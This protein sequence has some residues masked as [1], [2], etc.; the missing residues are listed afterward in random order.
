M[1]QHYGGSQHMSSTNFKRPLYILVDAHSFYA[2]CERVFRPDL[3]TKPVAVMS[4]NDGCI[5]AGTREVKELGIVLG[6]PVFK[7]RHLVKAHQI[8]LFSA[9]FTLYGDLSNRMMSLMHTFSSDV[10][11]YSVDECFIKINNY[12][13]PYELGEE[14]RKTIYNHIGLPVGV[15]LGPT[16]TLAKLANR[17]AKKNG[18]VFYLTEQDDHILSACPMDMVWGI[19]RNHYRHLARYGI[20]NA[21]H[22]KLAHESFVKKRFHVPGHRTQLELKGVPCIEMDLSVTAKKNILSSRSFGK[23]LTNKEDIKGAIGE[24]IATAATK[25]K[26][27]KAHTQLLTIFISTHRMKEDYYSRSHTISLPEPS[28]SVPYLTHHGLK[29]LDPIF[30]E[31]RSYVKS[32]VCFSQL[33]PARVSQGTLF[34]LSEKLNNTRLSSAWDKIVTKHGKTA[35]SIAQTAIKH[36]PWRMNQHHLSPKY[37]TQ[38][39]EIPTAY[40]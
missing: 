35:I 4:N 14:I 32:G 6:K 33:T 20:R 30:L 24:N 25:L 17:L 21:L 16:K 7:I 22:F 29:A 23:A 38:W 12:R 27:E 13:D 5:I 2:S 15:G 19:G 28:A 34:H 11:V 10:E 3:A 1:T 8:H 31:G 39:K 37:T 9:N 40:A 26:R 18:D 36:R